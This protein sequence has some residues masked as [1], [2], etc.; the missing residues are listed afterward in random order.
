MLQGLVATT[1]NSVA[2]L[3]LDQVYKRIAAWIT[4]WENYRLESEYEAAL[5]SKTFWFMLVNNT[6][7]LFWAA[8]Y[9]RDVFGLFKATAI[10]LI[11]KNMTNV[12]KDVTLPLGKYTKNLVSQIVYVCVGNI[13]RV[14]TDSTKLFYY[15]IPINNNFVIDR[16]ATCRK[17]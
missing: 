1:I 2:I 4:D 7:P 8:F 13:Y 10:Q 6:A 9:D 17:K 14:C 11:S 5:V 12:V 3:I 15:C 16:F